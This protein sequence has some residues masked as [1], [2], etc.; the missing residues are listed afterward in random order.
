[1]ATLGLPVNLVSQDEQF[2]TKIINAA[3]D[4]INKE[5]RYPPGSTNAIN[6]GSIV[7]V[8]AASITLFEINPTRFVSTITNTGGN[9]ASVCFGQVA[10]LGAGIPLP[11]LAVLVF[12]RGTDIPYTGKVTVISIAAATTLALTEVNIENL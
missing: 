7:N 9:A 3:V 10:I 4:K 5:L 6:L 2:F 11:P 8:A 1:M 12:G